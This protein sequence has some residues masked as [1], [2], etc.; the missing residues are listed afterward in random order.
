M[1]WLAISA[2]S[3]GTPAGAPG[4]ALPTSSSMK[5]LTVEIISR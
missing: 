3:W 2:A 4:W 1:Y 5:P